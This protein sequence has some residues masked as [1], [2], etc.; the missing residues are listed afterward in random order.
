MK[1]KNY[2]FGGCFQKNV[3]VKHIVYSLLIV[4]IISV[5]FFYFPKFYSTEIFLTF[6]LKGLREIINWNV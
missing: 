1:I 2:R 3:I 5:I 6:S 4:C